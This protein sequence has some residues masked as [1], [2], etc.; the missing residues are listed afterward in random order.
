MQIGAIILGVTEDDECFVCGN[1]IMFPAIA[2]SGFRNLPE[3]SHIVMH[4]G[5]ASKLA[6]QL[7]EDVTR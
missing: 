4:H 6:G 2:W 1:R 5:C 3:P 7:L